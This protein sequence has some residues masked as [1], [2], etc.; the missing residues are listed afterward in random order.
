MTPVA[1]ARD[2]ALLVAG[3]ITLLQTPRSHALPVLGAC[4]TVTVLEIAAGGVR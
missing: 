4:F 1:T 3:V 2:G